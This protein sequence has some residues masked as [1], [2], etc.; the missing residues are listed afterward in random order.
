MFIVRTGSVRVFNEE[1]GKEIS[2][3]AQDRRGVR[4]HCAA[5][6]VPAR[7]V[8]ACVGQDRAA[9]D[10]ARGQRAVVG[11]NPAAL[12]FITSYVAI[13]SAGGFVARL[14][15]LRGKLDKPSWKMPCA[16]WA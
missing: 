10:S 1:H 5:A 7:I 13:S 4:R 8:G 2:M 14:F 11:G 15:D 3:G 16:A 6:R 9:H 12:A